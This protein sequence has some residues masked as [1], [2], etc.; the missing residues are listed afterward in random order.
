MAK[1]NNQK[2]QTTEDVLDQLASLAM[3]D[4]KLRD[5]ERRKE[6]NKSVKKASPEQGV[7]EEKA[8]QNE[9]NG[10]KKKKKRKP[11]K[12]AEAVKDAYEENPFVAFA[13]KMSEGA[14]ALEKSVPAAEEPEEEYEDE[15]PAPKRSGSR[16][17]DLKGQS[18]KLGEEISK[19]RA[20]DII[21][22]RKSNRELGGRRATIIVHRT[23]VDTSGREVSE[24]YAQ[25]GE[26]ADI[27][28]EEP[29]EPVNEPVP[30]RT[31]LLLIRND[32]GEAYIIDEDLTIGREDDNDIVIPEPDG[33]YV[34]GY[35][36]EVY[37]KG[38]DIYLKDTGSTNGTF[39]NGSR[40]GSKRLRAGQN[41]RF[42]DVEFTVAEE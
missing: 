33:H 32:T 17:K 23:V 9:N 30:E 11:K 7:E 22:G 39:V 34:S 6:K 19:E 1:K 10:T 12:E 8:P 21:S 37:I 16:S 26:A 35:H 25:E 15:E 4:V 28:S 31:Q 29:K 38:K 36:A 27:R 5:E 18:R 42:A 2:V 14:K 13:E 40:I 20:E 41:V 24:E 3:E